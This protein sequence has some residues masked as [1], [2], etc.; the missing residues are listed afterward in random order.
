MQDSQVTT[1]VKKG[2]NMHPVI[3][4]TFGG[5]TRAYYF[6]QLFFG[7][8]FFAFYLFMISQSKNPQGAPIGALIIFIANTL[9]YPYSRF[10]YEGIA[11]FIFGNNV[12]FV[13]AILMLI[14]K[15][16]TMLLCWSLAI[17]IAPIGLLYLYYH[18]TKNENQ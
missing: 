13:N 9:L 18:H 14:V 17:F 3:G 2:E 7:F 1:L 15:L 10:V 4:K 12:F 16:V 5:L 6:R 11:G 8:I